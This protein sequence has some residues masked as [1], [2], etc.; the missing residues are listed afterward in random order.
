MSEV[1]NIG[2]A[3]TLDLPHEQVLDAAK[4][5]VTGGVIVLGRDSNDEMYAASSIGNTAEMLLL[6]E[7]FK[8]RL[9]MEE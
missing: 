7:R 9:L 2:T 8:H 3:T 6:L 4:G 1:V 5:I